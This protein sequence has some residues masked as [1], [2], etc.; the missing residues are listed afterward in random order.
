LKLNKKVTHVVPRTVKP[1]T[2]YL[3]IAMCVFYIQ[4]QNDDQK[5]VFAFA[6][7]LSPSAVLLFVIWPS[8]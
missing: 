1:I 2:V 3:H 6:D 4:I 5:A 7:F 8:L